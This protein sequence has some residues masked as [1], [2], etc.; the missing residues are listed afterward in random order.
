MFCNPV[1]IGPKQPILYL[2]ASCNVDRFYNM[3]KAAKLL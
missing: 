1:K 3:I 2:N